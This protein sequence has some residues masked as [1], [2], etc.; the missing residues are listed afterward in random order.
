MRSGV[1]TEQEGRVVKPAGHSRRRWMLGS[2]SR[3][4]SRAAAWQR[5][6]AHPS[7]PKA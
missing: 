3:N 5:R 4:R 7:T 2:G 1:N 6:L